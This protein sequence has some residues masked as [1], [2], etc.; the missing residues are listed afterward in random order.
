[1][2][3]AGLAPSQ[4]QLVS[5]YNF[6]Q[7][8][9]PGGSAINGETFEDEGSI[10]A[11]WAHN[12]PPPGTSNGGDNVGT[13][14]FSNGTGALYW[15]GTAGSSSLLGTAAVVAFNNTNFSTNSDTVTG[16]LMA[17]QGDWNGANMGLSVTGAYSVGF[18]QNMIGFAEA[19]LNDLTFAA[20]A[21][22]APITIDWTFNS[23]VVASTT[24]GTTWAAYTV[25]L[26]TGFYGSLSDLTAT[27]SGAGRL[28][29]VQFNGSL[30]AIPE[31]STYAAI[32]GVC[33]LGFVMYR[34][35]QSAAQL[36]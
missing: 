31:P 7:F 27:F 17:L 21:A 6:G 16:T 29:N 2:S 19:G 25:D 4:V 14:G 20:Q 28:D 23:L 36:A 34:R 30:A 5:G 1:M 24:V 9:G 26:P 32:L 22:T 11:N 3:L 10:G 18:Q 8:L 33:T 15:N 12:N 13:P 35:R